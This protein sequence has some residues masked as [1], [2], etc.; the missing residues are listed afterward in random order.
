MSCSYGPVMRRRLAVA[1]ALV[2]LLAAAVLVNAY[3]SPAATSGGDRVAAFGSNGYGELGDGTTTDRHAPAT[4]SGLDGVRSVAAGGPRNAHS[5]AVTDNGA[6]FAW[7]DN[8]YGELGDGTT[9]ERHV[10][11]KVPLEG[12]FT[13]VASSSFHSLAL[14]SDGTVWAW[15]QNNCGELG[16]VDD[17]AQ[18]PPGDGRAGA[19]TAE[20]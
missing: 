20:A 10:P 3:P 13:A 19:R 4:V 11:V 9:T 15:G 6:V 16:T 5:L 1:V 2:G 8:R 17:A 18:A 14:R 12:V 7:G